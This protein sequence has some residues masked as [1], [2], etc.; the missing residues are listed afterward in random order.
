VTAAPEIILA[1]ASP[2]RAE[3]LRELGRPFRIVTSAVAET[4]EA[5]LGPEGVALTNARRKAHAVAALHPEALV[6]GADTVVALGETLF[7]KPRDLAEAERFLL[8]LSGKTHAVITGVCLMHRSASRECSVRS[9]VEFHALTAETAREYI[10][11]VHVLDKAGAYAI[12]EH[13]DMIVRRME[14]SL[15]NVIGLP[16][17]TLERELAT[18]GVFRSG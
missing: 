16:M 12:Q 8:E 10:H 9:E 3:L 5:R 2:R 6:I 13:G 17:E 11:K 1:S 7:A 15:S 18:F 14:G 4:E